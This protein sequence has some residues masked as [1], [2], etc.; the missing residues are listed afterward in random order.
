MAREVTELFGKTLVQTC[1]VKNQSNLTR[2]GENCLLDQVNLLP[3]RDNSTT[4]KVL[5]ASLKENISA[6]SPP[7]L[8]LSSGFLTRLKSPASRQLTSCGI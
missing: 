6:M 4:P 5:C 7:G 1:E 3:C 8:F 2:R